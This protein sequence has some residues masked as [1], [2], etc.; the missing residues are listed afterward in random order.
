MLRMFLDSFDGPQRNIFEDDMDS[1]ESIRKTLRKRAKAFLE[2]QYYSVIERRVGKS[3]SRSGGRELEI[4]ESYAALRQEELGRPTRGRTDKWVGI[5]IEWL[6][7]ED[8][9]FSHLLFLGCNLLLCPL[10]Q[11]F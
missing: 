2:R 9:G 1:P 7:V 4:I 5:A 6:R 11:T 3:R 8:H 10:W